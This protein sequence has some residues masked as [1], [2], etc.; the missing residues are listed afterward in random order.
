MIAAMD[1]KNGI[2]KKGKIPWHLKHDLHRFALVTKGN[3][4]IMGR[5]TWESLPENH[6]PLAERTNIVITHD[7]EYVLPAGVEKAESLTEALEK[8]EH[9]EKPEALKKKNE[10]NEIPKIFIIGGG[11]IYEEGIK[12]DQCKDLWITRVKGDFHC[13][14]FFPEI[15]KNFKKIADSDH[16]HEPGPSGKIHF[17]FEIWR[18]EK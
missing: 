12:N 3:I 14:T 11:K 2:G 5:K 4:V 8:A 1:D 9:Y 17:E 15:P 13:D 10:M 6:R 16:F 18:K 7:A